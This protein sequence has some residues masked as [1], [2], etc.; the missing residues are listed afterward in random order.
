VS[1]KTVTN[2]DV[3][4]RSYPGPWRGELLLFCGKCQRRV[5]RE[6]DPEQITPLKKQLKARAKAAADG[7]QLN[8]LKVS[9]L[10][11]CPADGITVCTAGQV[12]K[13]ECSIVRTGGDLDKLC[14]LCQEQPLS[15]SKDAKKRRS[16]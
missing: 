9:C 4:L 3:A 10:K 8:V 7:L 6:G 13:H 15:W 14:A 12:A 16:R 1:K 5:K 11:M 2:E